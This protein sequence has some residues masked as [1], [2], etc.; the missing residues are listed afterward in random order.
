M[1]NLIIDDYKMK[2]T[3]D[4]EKT[5]AKGGFFLES[6]M[7]F[8]NLQRNIFQKTILNLKFKF[9]TQDSFLEYF[10][11]RFGDLKKRIALSEK[12]RL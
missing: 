9:R 1:I 4:L 7:C 3:K 6:A 8:S 11:W 2:S 5:I 10:F 12:S